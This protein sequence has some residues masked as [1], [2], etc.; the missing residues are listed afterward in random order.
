VAFENILSISQRPHLQSDGLYGYVA[1]QLMF[2]AGTQDT[3]GDKPAGTQEG[4]SSMHACRF[5]V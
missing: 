5:V 2:Q 1:A 3:S 4:H